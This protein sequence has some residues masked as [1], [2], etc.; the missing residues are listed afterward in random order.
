MGNIKLEIN[1]ESIKNEIVKNFDSIVDDSGDCL[2]K[3]VIKSCGYL[4][5]IDSKYFLELKTKNIVLLRKII[6]YLKKEFSHPIISYKEESGLNREKTY[7][8]EFSIGSYDIFKKIM[9]KR[10]ISKRCK[11]AYLV[12]IFLFS[13]T[14]SIGEHYSMEFFHE[15]MD[16]L[17]KLKKLISP[18]LKNDMKLYRMNRQCVLISGGINVIKNFF[19]VLG[20]TNAILEMENIQ[21]LRSIKNKANRLVNC[22]TGNL[23]KIIL[24]SQRH[25]K[26]IQY[27][28]ENAGEEYLSERLR[29]AARLRMNNPDMSLGELSNKSKGRFSKSALNHCFR[30]I[31]KIYI[32]LSEQ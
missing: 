18:L 3:G 23:K 4:K 24:S 2:I 28:F 17:K 26:Y 16:V 15:N 25:I 10:L 9:N 22:E 6:P 29:Q 20:L 8:I 5:V 1:N 27:I 31:K 14:I 13:G 7:F 21:I 32:E 12:G 19:D 11:T 30:E